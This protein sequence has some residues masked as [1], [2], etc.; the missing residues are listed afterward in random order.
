M[1]HTWQDAT[2]TVPKTCS[3][4]SVTE[5]ETAPHTWQEATTE[6][7]KTCSVCQKTEG[8]KLQTDSRF[9]TKSTKQFQG[10]W[11]SNILCTDEMMGLT[12]F[13][14]V[15]CVMTLTF[16]NIGNYTLSMNVK[17]EKDYI[18]KLKA[19][20]IEE[21]YTTFA[22]EGMSRAQAD[23]AML[24]AYGLNVP[25]YVDAALSNY[26]V[27]EVFDVFT[28]KGVYYV[29]GDKIC[30]AISWNAKFEKDKFT[31]E[32]GKLKIDNLSFEEGG[33]PLIWQRK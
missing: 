10:T 18:K 8:T 1:G 20:T 16:D 28:S 27:S 4:C 24:D 31:L 33:E 26:D 17:D 19:Y 14:D 9:T 21:L 13:G 22:Q 2:C 23:Q 11:I 3:V 5:G 29:E 25:D 12:N 6:A 32:N 7:P 15:E 30:T